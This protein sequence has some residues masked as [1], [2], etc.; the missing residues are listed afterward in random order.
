MR[1]QIVGAAL[2]K[3]ADDPEIS[4]ALFEVLETQGMLRSP[5]L[6]VT[7]VPPGS[8]VLVDPRP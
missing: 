5:D 3:I 7:L 1:P 2:A 8:T 4:K 6:R